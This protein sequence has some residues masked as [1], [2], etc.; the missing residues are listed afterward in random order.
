MANVA[1]WQ[2]SKE[3]GNDPIFHGLA[4]VTALLLVQIA[5]PPQAQVEGEW[6]CS[7]DV[8]LRFDQSGPTIVGS[9]TDEDIVG[10]LEGI[11]Q[12][13]IFKGYYAETSDALDCGIPRR[14]GAVSSQAWGKFTLTFDAEFHRFDGHYSYCFGPEEHSWNGER[15]DLDDEELLHTTQ[16]SVSYLYCYDDKKCPCQHV[17]VDMA[18]HPQSGRIEVIGQIGN[19]PPHVSFGLNQIFED[20]R[21]ERVT[22]QYNVPA[23]SPFEM[24][25]RYESKGEKFDLHICAG[26]YSEIGT[27]NTATFDINIW[28]K[29][30]EP[31]PENAPEQEQLPPFTLEFVSAEPTQDIGIYGPV[32]DVSLYLNNAG[33]NQYRIQVEF[34]DPPPDDI[35]PL[36]IKIAA[37]S[38]ETGS[39]GATMTVRTSDRVATDYRN[40]NQ[41][42][43]LTPAFDIC[44]IE[45]PEG[46]DMVRAT[47]EDHTTEARLDPDLAGDWSTALSGTR[48]GSANEALRQ[49]RFL[50]MGNSQYK[51]VYPGI[52]IDDNGL[53]GHLSGHSFTGHWVDDSALP[54]CV[55]PSRFSGS[56]YWAKVDL[57]FNDSMTSFTGSWTTCGD[58]DGGT[59]HGAKIVPGECGA[60]RP[61]LQ[62]ISGPGADLSL[63]II[64]RGTDRPLYSGIGTPHMTDFF[65]LQ[66]ANNEDRTI[67]NFDLVFERNISQSEYE[68]GDLSLISADDQ[69]RCQRATGSLGTRYVEF[70]CA[71]NLRPDGNVQLR[72]ENRVRLAPDGDVASCVSGAETLIGRLEYDGYEENVTNNDIRLQTAANATASNELDLSDPYEVSCLGGLIQLQNA[73]TCSETDDWDGDGI[74]NPID[75]HPNLYSNGFEFADAAVKGHIIDRA[76]QTISITALGE[77]VRFSSCGGTQEATIDLWGWEVGMAPGSAFE[78]DLK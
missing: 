54:R 12:D 4:P 72:L 39:S 31:E 35:E 6:V 29:E 63:N 43:F 70:N 38:G 34:L 3:R 20:G 13:H 74:A 24:S 33:S 23:G 26:W 11:L 44:S 61:F 47:S 45:W 48:T 60:D 28:G 15:I 1:N 46:A 9:Y 18:E 57:D 58:G 49:L 40:L 71:T 52:N 19:G 65:L 5:T 32:G 67:Y 10:G 78:S 62:R 8:P 56:P 25:H 2:A 37:V 50:A 75:I 41:R 59:W 42:T 64:E 14:A 27:A 22:F 30:P 51:A 77:V 53:W 36:D 17:Y 76:D 7:G 21:N 55:E 16:G 68:P 69:A 66:V 73:P